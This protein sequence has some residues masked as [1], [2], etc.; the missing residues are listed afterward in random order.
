MQ[1]IT[2]I[3]KYLFRAAGITVGILLI[4]VIASWIWFT[5]LDLQSQRNNIEKLASQA[6]ARKVQIDGPIH[7]SASLFPRISIANVRIANPPWAT[8]PELLVVDELELEINLLALLRSKLVINDIKLN[9]ATL[10]LQIDAENGSTWDLQAAA[11][12]SASFQLIPEIIALNT[13]NILIIFYPT[14]R[15]PIE[16]HIDELQ[17][18]LKQNTPMKIRVISNI[19]DLPLNIELQGGSLAQLFNSDTRWPMTGSLDTDTRKIDFEGYITDLFSLKEV[20]LKLSSDKQIPRTSILF[21]QNFEPLVDHYQ[22]GLNINKAG[23]AYSIKLYGE[24][25]GFDLSRLYQPK[26]RPQKPS[27]KFQDFKINAQGSGETLSEILKSIQAEISASNIKY[28]HPV[29]R[30]D[31]KYFHAEIKTLNIKSTEKSNF[32]VVLHGSSNHVPYKVHG[33]F[34]GILI[35]LWTGKPAPLNISILSS[36]LKAQLKGKISHDHKQLTVSAKA[37]VQAENL[38]FLAKPFALKWPEVA[39]L[40]ASGQIK[41]IGHSLLLTDIKGQLGSQKVNGEASLSYNNEFMLSIK[42]N[43]KH[44]DIHQLLPENKIPEKLKLSLNGLNIN[45]QGKSTNFFQSLLA[46]SWDI[47]AKGGQIGWRSSPLSSGTAADYIFSL[48]N[49]Q[50]EMHEQ[51]PISLTA[52]SLY[53]NLA[54]NVDAQLGSINQ[55]LDTTQPYPLS[56][57]LNAKDLSA[58]F[59]G[60]LQK[61]LTDLILA[62]DLTMKSQAATLGQ[63]INIPIKRKQSVNAQGHITITRDDLKL[64]RITAITDGIEINGELNYQTGSSP[65]LEIKSS[66]SS[67]DLAHYMNKKAKLKKQSSKKTK[68]HKRIIPDIAFDFSHYNS[69]DAA[70]NIKELSI[71]YNATPVIML[72][73]QFTAAKGIFVLDSIETRSATN[74]STSLSR[75]EL[76]NSLPV[77]RFK[78]ELQANDINYGEILRQ[79][80][81]TDELNGSLDININV[82]GQGKNLHKLIG[83]TNGELQVIAAKG[84][85]PKWLLEIWGAGLLRILVPT[86]WMEEAVT[87]LNCAVG[88]FNLENGTMTSQTLLADTRRV[89]VAGEVMLNWQTEEIEGIFESQP[90]DVTL[91]RIGTPLKLSGTLLNPRISSAESGFITLGKWAIGLSNPATIIV[92]FGDTGAKDKNPCAALLTSPGSDSH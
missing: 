5:T 89:T 81:I 14:D 6:L 7:L 4:L 32:T 78:Y 44:F 10:H 47:S 38:R 48:N 54:L 53:N 25:Y 68:P 73:G 91:M 29:N 30:S 19:N 74:D 72:S 60:A 28:Q 26:L 69:L 50:L 31:K 15:P 49:I 9:G 8:H 88:K 42:A 62:G 71:E 92:L 80:K 37:S 12:N 34:G 33:S 3:R 76:N 13:R 83:S 64:S 17:A 58:S 35:A 86:T 84:S 70:I 23:D 55:L 27:V 77:P 52:K 11:K 65:N 1:R 45:I 16:I 67:I 24:F 2:L 79:L 85:V 20:E 43:A 63:L 56:L 21:G 61:P 87:D 90:K 51:K 46:G 66:D 36:G 22:A 75:I 57:H 59:Q 39:A 82:T 40:N 41:I 18:S